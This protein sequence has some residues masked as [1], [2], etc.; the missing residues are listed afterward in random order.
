MRPC[1]TGPRVVYSYKGGRTMTDKDKLTKLLEL[2]NAVPTDPSGGH[3]EGIV[4]V[5]FLLMVAELVVYDG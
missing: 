1:I 3:I 4:W 2:I 5:E